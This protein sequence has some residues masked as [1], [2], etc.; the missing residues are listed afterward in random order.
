MKDALGK[1]DAQLQALEVKREGAY[2]ELS[3]MVKTSHEAQL[4]LRGE[5]SQLLQALRAPTSR[6]AWGQM[7]IETYSGNDRHVGAC[8]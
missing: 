1:L 2:R 6:G 4:Q 3:Q 5:T 7:Q 8:A